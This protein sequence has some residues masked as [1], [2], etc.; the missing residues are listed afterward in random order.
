METLPGWRV[1]DFLEPS[2]AA[3]G[4]RKTFE[5][6]LPVKGRYFENNMSSFT[7]EAIWVPEVS[8]LQSPQLSLFIPRNDLVDGFKKFKEANVLNFG[9]G[10][11]DHESFL[12]PQISSSSL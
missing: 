1:D 2:F 7:S 10:W 9:C 6:L 5:Q 11:N 8:P 12:V 3:N 4:F